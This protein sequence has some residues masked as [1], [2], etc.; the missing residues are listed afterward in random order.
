M[1][2]LQLFVLSFSKRVLIRFICF[3]EF[4]NKADAQ[5]Q[6]H[7]QGPG[8]C[9]IEPMAA[10]SE[11]PYSPANAGYYH[12]ADQAVLEIGPAFGDLP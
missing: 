9:A 3:Y 6:H 2:V 12:K 10:G 11:K 5:T 8:R 7:P 4:K 1:L